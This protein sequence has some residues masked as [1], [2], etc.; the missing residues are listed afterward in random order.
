M[1]AAHLLTHTVTIAAPA[2]ISGAGD[3]AYGA[4][5]TQKVRHVRRSRVVA[6]PN[7]TELTTN[8][9]LI[10]E[11]AIPLESRV[12]LPGIDTAQVNLAQRVLAVEQA[13]TFTGYT[14]YK[15]YC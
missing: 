15:A 11:T 10:S 3:F 6:G 4:Q 12:W 14:L 5:Y 8:N 1:N 13:D 2:S 7:G 9:E